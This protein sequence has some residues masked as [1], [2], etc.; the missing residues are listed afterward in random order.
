MGIHTHGAYTL[1]C[2]DDV[3]NIVFGEILTQSEDVR[4]SA[5][6]EGASESY[7]KFLDI[8]LNI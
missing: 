5:M 4:D 1:T 7:S 8:L 3:A 2:V 6:R